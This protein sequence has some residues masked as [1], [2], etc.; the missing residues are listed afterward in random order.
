MLRESTVM[1]YRLLVRELDK[2]KGKGGYNRYGMTSKKNIWIFGLLTLLLAASGRSAPRTVHITGPKAFQLLSVLASAN[3]TI[4]DTLGR[5]QTLVIHNLRILQQSTQKYDSNSASY[6]LAIYRAEGRIENAEEISR[7][8]EATELFKFIK[9]LGFKSSGI[10]FEGGWLEIRT[11]A[12][13]VDG[14]AA[15]S[16]DKRFQCELS[17]G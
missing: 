15:F 1:N 10:T 12:C 17:G 13:K 11:V 4:K 14:S 16:D 7:L 9:K 5:Q 3:E 8:G 6:K 2:R